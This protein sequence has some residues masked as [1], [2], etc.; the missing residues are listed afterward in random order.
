LSG[1]LAEKAKTTPDNYPLSLNAVMTGCNQKSNRFPQM[2]LDEGQVQEALDSLRKAGAVALIQG[3]SRVEKYRHLLYD[4]LGVDKAE[5][6]V[7]TELL[8]RG[9]Q[10]IGELRGRAARME[11]IKDVGELMPIIDRLRQKGLVLYLTPPGRGGVVTHNLYQP[12]ELVKV[13]AEHVAGAD[14][15]YAPPAEAD[16][17]LA[18]RAAPVAAGSAANARPIAASS[19]S[20][21]A[22][23]PPAVGELE[24]LRADVASLSRDLADFREQTESALG[25]LRREV[26][27]LK[28]QLGV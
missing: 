23:K 10:T 13:R 2:T 16:P 5:L 1:V 27:D 22:A 21:V 17:L 24:Q 3:D 4:W 26:Q 19:G 28:S 25:D 15:E 9:A 6:A 8:L 11:P 7:M 18:A 20:R 14:A 12:Q